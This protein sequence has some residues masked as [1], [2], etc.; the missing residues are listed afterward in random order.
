[1]K[2]ITNGIEPLWEWEKEGYRVVLGAQTWKEGLRT[3]RELVLEMSDADGQWLR[4]ESSVCA[5]V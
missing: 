4:I 5:L 1:M 3:V 2:A